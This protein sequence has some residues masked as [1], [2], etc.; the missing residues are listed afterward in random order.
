MKKIIY[1]IKSYIHKHLHKSIKVAQN[2]TNNTINS[3]STI[4]TNNS[5]IS[6]NNSIYEQ[7]VY[8]FSSINMKFIIDNS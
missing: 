2:N 1:L 6:I 5:T 7:N 8:N 4:S 3:N